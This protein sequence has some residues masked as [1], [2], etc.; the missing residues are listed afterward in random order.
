MAMM[1]QGTHIFLNR[2]LNIF[3]EEGLYS[4]QFQVKERVLQVITRLHR[5]Q[6]PFFPQAKRYVLTDDLGL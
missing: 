5:N 3:S 1:T 4:D 2:S 6:L